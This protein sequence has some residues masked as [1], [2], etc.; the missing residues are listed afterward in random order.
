MDTLNRLR[1]ENAVA[2]GVFLFAA[3]GAAVAIRLLWPRGSRVRRTAIRTLAAVSGTLT[4]LFALEFAFAFC[5]QSDAFGGSL[6]SELWFARYWNPINS[7]GYR[8]TSIKHF[9]GRSVLF[10][11]GDSFVAGHGIRHIEDRFADRLARLL[12]DDWELAIIG[13]NS[14]DTSMEEDGLRRYPTK[15]NLVVLSY[16]IND[17]QGA[18]E[19]NG[20]PLPRYFR[21]PSGIL[22]PFVEQSFFVNWA[23]WRV[24]R[25]GMG[26]DYW[27][28]LSSAFANPTIWKTHAAEL[29]SFA[30]TVAARDARLCVVVWPQLNR[31]R[32]SRAF[33]DRVVDL[34][35]RSGA[36]V[37][38]LAVA[39]DGRSADD[40]IVNALDIHPNER[41]DAE[42]AVL[43][44]DE[45]R[46]S[47]S[48][49]NEVAKRSGAP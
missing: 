2:F 43:I 44:A 49:G 35:H 7:Y 32:E 37:V 46:R 14:W 17:I 22:A 25:H 18:A 26:D 19:R 41:T 1:L 28:Y 42:V 31:I 10:V 34:F 39:L 29:K 13:D 23:Y 12:G 45:L 30:A 38:D 5:V 8:D 15:P 11:V 47:G 3:A 24:Y 20:F 48:T 36:T 27:N 40:L 16:Y 33:T 21:P 6:A 4:A 9:E